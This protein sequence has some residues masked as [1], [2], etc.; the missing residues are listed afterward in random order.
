M[1]AGRNSFKM[2]G[3]RNERKTSNNVAEKKGTHLKLYSW[4]YLLMNTNYLKQAEKKYLQN[5]H[6]DY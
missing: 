3:N 4:P 5:L 2:T 1:F 6:L